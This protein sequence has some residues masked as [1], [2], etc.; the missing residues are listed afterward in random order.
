M[1]IKLCSAT[2][3]DQTLHFSVHELQAYL[4]KML[5]AA[6]IQIV[7]LHTHCDNFQIELR[8]ENEAAHSGTDAFQIDISSSG[9]YICGNSSRSVL[10]AVYHYLYLLGCRFLGP[11]EHYE[12]IPQ[13]DDSSQLFCTDSY[14]ARYQY[15]GICLEGAN[16][17]DNIV[18]MI[19][20]LPKVGYNSFF[21]QFQIP[22][23]F[24]A[25]WYQHEN[26]PTL[27]GSAFSVA[28]A[29]AQLAQI[30]QALK[31]RGLLL[32]QVGHG[33]TNACLN[34][35]S[36][37]WE[38][39]EIQLNQ[40]QTSMLAELNGKRA[41]F[42]GVP[43]NSNLCYSNPEVIHAFAASV[44]D[45]AAAHPEIDYL[46]V[47]L[48]D[49][50]NNI[51]ECE[52]CRDELLADQ[53]IHLLNEID[54]RLQRRQLN[55]KLVFL[56]YQELLWPPRTARLEHP[57]RFVLMFAPISRT[58][59]ASYS[60][61][62]SLPAI[63]EFNRNHITLPTNLDENLAFLRSWQALFDGDSFVYDYPLGRAHY[64]DFGYSHIARVISDDISQLD[65]LQMDGYISCQELRCGMPNFL[66]NYVMGKK[67]FNPALSFEAIKTEYM[68]SAYGEAAPQVSAY[69]DR[70]SS[71]CDCD[72][73]NG[74]GSRSN[75][76]VAAHMKEAQQLTMAFAASEVFSA[77]QAVQTQNTF[78]KLLAHHCRCFPLLEQA[79]SLLAENKTEDARR[80]W[81]EFCRNIRA[82]EIDFQDALDVYRIIEVTEKYT[83]LTEIK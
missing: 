11:G 68:S 30:V 37:G 29:E 49:E 60:I 83:G 7:P 4:S 72:Y 46:H 76:S 13:L 40:Q 35:K 20:W 66:P 80:A 65:K 52:N 9:G 44:V 38:K 23:A 27:P 22:Y 41:L 67:L 12:F 53:Y 5:P 34:I 6:N 45:Y 77:P 2:P 31:K 25:R 21:I 16:S 42:H 1:D 17:L 3:K 71:L 82:G 73:Y 19:D 75:A 15:R 8:T 81:T 69:L 39:T 50:F 24:L 48:A 26:N 61:S 79:L 57:E 51:C 54:V 56:L 14:T 58:F 63:P 18:S 47:W 32:H 33:W 55:T 36:F 78:I 28:D 43:L 74:K 64:G 70:L 59:R 62:D 10:L